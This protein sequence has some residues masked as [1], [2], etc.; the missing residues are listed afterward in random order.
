VAQVVQRS[1]QSG[2]FLAPAPIYLD[3]SVTFAWMS[4]G[5]R[6]HARATTFI[7]DHLA[8]QR[9]LH[10]SLLTLDETIWRLLRGLVAQSR[11]VPVKSISLGRELK[12]NPKLL[13]AF[14]PNIRLAVGYVIGW[15]T[16]VNGGPTTAKGVLDSWLDRCDD[17]GGLHDALHLSLAQHSGSNSLVTVDLDFQSL[18]VL[19]K[20]MH[21]IT[22]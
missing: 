5:D 12:Q 1:W 14:L 3:S 15:A 17:V 21:V 9:E 10:V 7:G 6:L 16:L 4:S 11:S 19:P 22:I 13:S 8:A 20:P 2:Q 18:K